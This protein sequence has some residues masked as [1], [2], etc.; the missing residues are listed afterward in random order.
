LENK[1]ATNYQVIGSFTQRETEMG[2]YSRRA[3]L[4]ALRAFTNWKTGNFTLF[5]YALP[6]AEFVDGDILIH[7]H[8]ARGIGMSSV[9]T[10]NHVGR[11][12]RFCAQHKIPYTLN[13]DPDKAPDEYRVLG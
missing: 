9:T 4:Y 2:T 6:I 1:V 5:S 8:T 7:D 12:R 3:G 13:S 10:S 11:V